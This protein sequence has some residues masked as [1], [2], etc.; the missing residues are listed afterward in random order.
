MTERQHA[1]P[2][3]FVIAGAFL[4]TMLGPTLPTPL[5]PLYEEELHF[6]SL[7]VTLIF[8]TYAVGVA[9]ALILF[10]RLS[11]QIGRRK[12]L[13]PGLALAA[14]SSAVFLIPDSLTALFVGRVLSGLSVG[15][16]TGTATAALADLAPPGQL[17]RYSLIAAVVN[18]LG[19][20][21]GPVLAGGLAQFITAPLTVPFLVHIVAAL[22]AMVGVAVIAEP[23]SPPEGKPQWRIQRLR[24]PRE[25]RGTFVRASTAGFAGFAVLGLFASIAPALLSQ[26][27]HIGN[28]LV[29]GLVVFLQLGFSAIGQVCSTR[30][31]DEIGLMVGTAT[32]AVGISLT[33]VSVATASLP[34]L[35]GGAVVAGMGQGMGFRA[36]LSAINAASPS[37]ARGEITSAFFLV[38]YVAQAVPVIGVGMAAGSVG[39]VTAAVAF[40]ATIAAVSLGAFLSLVLA[41]NAGGRP[42]S[43]Q[44]ENTS[45]ADGERA[46]LKGGV[47]R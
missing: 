45:G 6:G 24:L 30:M 3:A 15:I 19:L 17:R 41:R 5:Y 18:M 47:R 23:S 34:V 12:L 20:G 33:G 26:I 38:L 10:G 1:K 4:V 8:A 46:F 42:G 9:A 25:V 22:L 32:M 11:D 2:A 14:L 29:C 44:A 35:L 40:A 13:L 39:L 21:L 28:H 31:R 37:D 7:M 16:F 43:G 36:A 27:L